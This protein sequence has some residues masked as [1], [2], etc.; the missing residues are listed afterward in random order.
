MSICFYEV[1]FYKIIRDET[2]KLD[3]LEAMRMKLK[4]PML[5]VTYIDKSVEFY[6]K[7]FEFHVIMDFEANKTLTDGLALQTVEIY[8]DF[9]EKKAIFLLA[10]ITFKF[11]LKKIILMNLRIS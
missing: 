11:T 9:I 8:Q 10:A 1:I 7:V 5:I 3:F 2:E 4:N 6:K